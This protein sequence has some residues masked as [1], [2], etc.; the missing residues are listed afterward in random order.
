MTAKVG[1]PTLRLIRN[2][3]ENIRLNH[4]QPGEM[5]ALSEE[6]IYQKL[7]LKK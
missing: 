3:I 6:E 7:L 5:I 2:S 4:M 1:F